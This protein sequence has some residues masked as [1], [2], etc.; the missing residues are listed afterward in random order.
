MDK[1]DWLKIIFVSSLFV[2]FFLMGV[3]LG[4]AHEPYPTSIGQANIYLK[5]KAQKAAIDKQIKDQEIELKRLELELMR[6]KGKCEELTPKQEIELISFD[7]I[8]TYFDDEEPITIAL[9]SKYRLKQKE[10]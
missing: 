2:L 7:F 4:Q 1:G 8:D 6:Q 5:I 9:P 3:K 10:E